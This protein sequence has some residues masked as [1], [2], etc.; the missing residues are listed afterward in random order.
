MLSGR[1][2]RKRVLQIIEHSRVRLQGGDRDP[3]KKDR[4]VYDK[5][6]PRIQIQSSHERE[7]VHSVSALPKVDP[8]KA[9]GLLECSP[10]EKE[11]VSH[12]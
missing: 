2:I 4:L 12:N 8:Y 9:I 6:Q 5:Q 3:E 10:Y 1:L 7:Q 11:N